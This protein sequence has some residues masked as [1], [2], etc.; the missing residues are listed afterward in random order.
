MTP[1]DQL[2]HNPVATILAGIALLLFVASLFDDLRPHLRRS[3]FSGLLLAL[4]AYAA[5]SAL[6][7][8]SAAALQQWSCSP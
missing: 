2:A 7:H 1:A 6:G 5:D 4:A 8:P 3:V